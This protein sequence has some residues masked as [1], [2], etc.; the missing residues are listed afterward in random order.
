[1]KH[2]LLIV[3]VILHVIFTVS[4]RKEPDLEAERV[5]IKE[6][7]QVEYFDFKG[8]MDSESRNL[9]QNVVVI[10]SIEQLENP[11]ETWDLETPSV[12]KQFD[13]EKYTL[14]LRFYI[15]L[16]IRKDIEHFVT[17][18]F[19]TGTYTYLIIFNANEA[20]FEDDRANHSDIFFVHTGVLIDKIAEDAKIEAIQGIL[21][22]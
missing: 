14:L 21:G 13:Y 19:K 2:Q 22:R 5:P 18:N 6:S 4:C 12:L 1:M 10:N 15:D 16:R 3:S 17:H 11:F 9:L 7:L 20:Y 8:Q